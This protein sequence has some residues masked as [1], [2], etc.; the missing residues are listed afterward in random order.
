MGIHAPLYAQSVGCVVGLLPSWGS[1]RPLHTPLSIATLDVSSLR[2]PS[3]GGV[4]HQSQARHRPGRSTAPS[5][6]SLDL[7]SLSLSLSLS[8]CFALSHSLCLALSHSLSLGRSQSQSRPVPV[9]VSVSVLV[10]ETLSVS[11]LLSPH[12]WHCPWAFRAIL[13]AS[14][15]SYWLGIAAGPFTSGQF[16]WGPRVAHPLP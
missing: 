10:S 15:C 14:L 8:P 5:D 16:R 7:R 12:S 4:P 2:T 9:S 11:V 1:P 6:L 13:D 3:V